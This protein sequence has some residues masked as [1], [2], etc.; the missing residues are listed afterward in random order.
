MQ[1]I[2]TS[3]AVR[4]SSNKNSPSCSPLSITF[5]F[6]FLNHFHAHGSFLIPAACQQLSEVSV[7]LD[8]WYRWRRWD[9]SYEGTGLWSDCAEMQAQ[10][11]E[12][13]VPFPLYFSC[14]HEWK[15]KEPAL[16]MFVFMLVEEEVKSLRYWVR[17]QSLKPWVWSSGSDDSV[18]CEIVIK[19][20]IIGKLLTWFLICL[21]KGIVLKS[22]HIHCC[23][24]R[25]DSVRSTW[26]SAMLVWCGKRG[27]MVGIQKQVPNQQHWPLR[28]IMSW[29]EYII[30]QSYIYIT[31]CGGGRRIWNV[32]FC[33]TEYICE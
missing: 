1:E 32:C 7:S 26:V 12:V 16:F 24:R 21:Y 5:H 14:F 13:T 20:T 9:S 17:F 2:V 28:T 19:N 27:V 6:Q 4:H 8:P 10:V 30:L 25:F 33:K 29:V 31:L 3:N 11:L 15:W 23:C 22:L 18:F